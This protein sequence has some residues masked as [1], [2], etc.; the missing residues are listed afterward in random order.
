MQQIPSVLLYGS[1]L[2]MAVVEASLQ[3]QPDLA[4]I[5]VNPACQASRQQLHALA[6]RVVI[7]ESDHD[8]LTTSCDFATLATQEFTPTVI[9]FKRSAN[10]QH[11]VVADRLASVAD[12]DE[13]LA[14]IRLSLNLQS[15]I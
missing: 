13:L 3:G 14:L 10:N 12:A 15:I 9:T 6:P 1:S 11:A 5:R 7:V 2:F 8:D 4:V